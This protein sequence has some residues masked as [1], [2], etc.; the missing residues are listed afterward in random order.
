MSVG[1]SF[2]KSE[3]FAIQ[4]LMMTEIVTL[5]ERSLGFEYITAVYTL[6]IERY[7]HK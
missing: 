6:R 2:G 1:L 3:V 7:L 5:L 4:L